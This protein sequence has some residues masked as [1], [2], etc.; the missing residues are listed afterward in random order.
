MLVEDKHIDLPQGRHLN[1]Q[2]RREI[3]DDAG[4]PR[5][6]SATAFNTSPL[7]I[8]ICSTSQSP[9]ARNSERSA[10]AL[11]KRLAPEATAI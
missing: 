6:A 4:A 1:R 7:G 9:A 11:V 5:L 3:E 8:S 10:S 2:G